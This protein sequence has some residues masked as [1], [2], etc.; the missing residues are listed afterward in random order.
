MVVCRHSS[1]A[2]ATATA[3][4]SALRDQVLQAGEQAVINISSLNYRHLTQ[5]V[6][7]WE[8]STTGSLRA[9]ILAGRAD[10]ERTVTQSR[11]VTTA[12]ILDGAITV[13]GARSATFIVA[14]Q[15][16]VVAG[17]GTPAVSQYRMVGQLT[18]TASGWKLSALNAAQAGAAS[19]TPAG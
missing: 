2:A 10:L 17:S 19:T 14:E 7:L 13:L 1:H 18:K 12:K 4:Q 15:T 5:G 11:S 6:G 3:P 16:T 8:Q 9:G